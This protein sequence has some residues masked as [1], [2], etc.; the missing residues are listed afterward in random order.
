MVRRR[1]GS[2]PAR[3]RGAIR[4]HQISTGRAGRRRARSSYACIADPTL[5]RR[6]WPDP[7]DVEH[8]T[9]AAAR[10]GRRGR[11]A[12]PRRG[13]WPALALPVPSSASAGS[14]RR[15][16][17]REVEQR[18]LFP[19]LAVAV[20]RRHPRC[21]SRPMVRR[22]LG[23]ALGLCA[24]PAAATLPAR[25][26]GR[27][28]WRCL[29][30]AAGLRGFRGGALRGSR[31]RRPGPAR[32]LIGHGRRLRRERWTSAEVGA[33]L[34]VRVASLDGLAAAERPRRVR[35]S[36][37]KAPIRARPGDLI[38]AT[39]PPAAAAGGRPAGRLRFR[40]RRLFPGHRR[41]RLADLGQVADRRRRPSPRASGLRLAAAAST[42][43]ATR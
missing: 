33:R 27:P 2:D 39:R 12:W 10:A 30:L 43:P 40:P 21:S 6:R 25:A 42:R 20:R 29:A 24:A 32:A 5:S 1:C 22:A 3:C 19:W 14:R 16:A 28:R 11:C 38:A 34:V 7:M 15:R 26:A 18:R 36:F 9:A 41:G 23:A 31:G 4:R 37:R 8:R 17:R 13:A 35:V